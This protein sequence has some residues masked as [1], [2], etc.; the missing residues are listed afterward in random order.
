MRMGKIACECGYIHS[1]TCGYD[2]ALLQYDDWTDE[3]HNDN[4]P[5]VFE[6]CECGNLM[7]DD[8]KNP[9][10]MITYRPKNGKYNKILHNQEGNEE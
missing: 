8:P 6:C 9:A 7:I 3:N 1:N 10:M 2:G 4:A 5:M